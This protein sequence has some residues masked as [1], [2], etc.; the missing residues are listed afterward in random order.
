M[1]Y[2]KTYL[3][4]LYFYIFREIHYLS[5]GNSGESEGFEGPLL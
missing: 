5:T 3:L 4:K 2:F 1:M